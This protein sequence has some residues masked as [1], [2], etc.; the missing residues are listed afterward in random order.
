M[1]CLSNDWSGSFTM[2]SFLTQFPLRE[3]IM[4]VS[5][6]CSIGRHE[7]IQQIR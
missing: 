3:I 4:I 1:Q 6:T 7:M 5:P 2:H